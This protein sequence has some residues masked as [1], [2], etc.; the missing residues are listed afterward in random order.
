MKKK[1]ADTIRTNQNDYRKSNNGG[2]KG[3][4]DIRLIAKRQMKYKVSR[5]E[6]MIKRNER[7]NWKCQHP[8]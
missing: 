5:R 6:E 7:Q 2:N 1:Q 3:L 8:Y 4:T